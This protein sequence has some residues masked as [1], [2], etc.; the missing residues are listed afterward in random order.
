MVGRPV[1]ISGCMRPLSDTCSAVAIVVSTIGNVEI[2]GDI[3]DVKL[4]LAPV[5]LN[6]VATISWLGSRSSISLG[7]GSTIGSLDEF[8][9]STIDR[10]H[11]EKSRLFTL[12]DS[13]HSCTGSRSAKIA[14]SII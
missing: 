13:R 9:Q 1:S 7:I 6:E 3:V 14:L 12:S 8:V 4:L 2:D 10:P 5:H 11:R